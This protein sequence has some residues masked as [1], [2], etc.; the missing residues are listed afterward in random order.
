VRDTTRVAMRRVFWTAFALLVAWLLWRLAARTDWAAVLASARSRPPAALA[1]IAAVALAG[2]AVYGLLDVAAR[3]LAGHRLPLWRTWLTATTCY[4]TNLN[5]GGAV[6]GV[7]MRLRLYGLQGVAPT[8]T[9]VV[10]ASAVLANWVGYLVLLAS[11]PLWVGDDGL[12]R[13]VGQGGAVAISIGAA[14]LVL[15]AAWASAR[16]F[17]P[18]VRGHEFPFAPPRPAALQLAVAVGNWLLMGTTLW[19]C[20]GDAATFAQA[21]AALLIAAVASAVAHVPGGLG[22]LDFILVTMLAG[23]APEADLVAGVLLY[24]AAYYLL[25]LALAMPGYLLLTRTAAAPAPGVSPSGSG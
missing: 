23:A 15:A 12:D 6:G 24:R 3:R 13:W 22:V 16:G 1:A 20:L 2:H 14:V 19:L 7:G 8:R 21:L 18:K 4:A 25:P 5:L 11:L 10:I 9:G 17:A